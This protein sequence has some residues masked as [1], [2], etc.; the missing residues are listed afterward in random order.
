MR[1]IGRR[2]FL[3]GLR[4]YSLDELPCMAQVIRPEKKH[5]LYF[6]TSKDT[7]ATTRNTLWRRAQADN[8]RAFTVEPRTWHSTSLCPELLRHRN[9]L[10]SSVVEE[11]YPGLCVRNLGSG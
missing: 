1:Q 4:V 9:N 11:G 3:S 6:P 8:D 2:I 7:A 5:H 10:F